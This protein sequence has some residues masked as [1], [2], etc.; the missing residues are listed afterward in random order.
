MDEA[1]ELPRDSCPPA[2]PVLPLPRETARR[3]G[4]IPT[5]GAMM[6]DA[7][8][9]GRGEGG[10]GWTPPERSAAPPDFP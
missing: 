2:P 7:E 4:N 10:A 9:R 8:E 6:P 1:L 3:I 5:G